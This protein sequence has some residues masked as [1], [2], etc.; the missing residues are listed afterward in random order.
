MFNIF[1]VPFLQAA[2]LTEEQIG[3]K[4]VNSPHYEDTNTSRLLFTKRT[5]FL[6]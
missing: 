6:P 2:E 3:G 1:V 4:R 5:Y